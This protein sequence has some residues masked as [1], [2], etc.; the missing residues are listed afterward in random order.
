M[1]R[2][3]GQG[4]GRLDFVPSFVKSTASR[5]GGGGGIHKRASKSKDAPK[6]ARVIQISSFSQEVIGYYAEEGIETR[7]YWYSGKGNNLFKPRR[8]LLNTRNIL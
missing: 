3:G 4:Q 1:R 2:E 6:P 7:N 8:S 5:Q